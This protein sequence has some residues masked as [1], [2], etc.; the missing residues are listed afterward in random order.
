VDV[1][2]ALNFSGAPGVES[3][4]AGGY[5]GLDIA[6]VTNN[7][8]FT[9]ANLASLL[10]STF[11]GFPASGGIAP[12][13][14]NPA[15]PFIWY[16]NAGKFAATNIVGNSA[17]LKFGTPV[18]RPTSGTKTLFVSYLLSIAQQGQ[19]GAGNE[20]RYLAFVSSTN[21]V[22]GTNLGPTVVAFTNWAAMFN[23]F[24]T[25]SNHYACHGILQNVGNVSYYIG[26]CDSS[27]GK[28]WANSPLSVNF[29]APA[30]VVGAYVLNSGANQDTNIMW[31][32][33]STTTF[34]G[35]TPP[36]T[37]MQV[38][39]TNL[40]TMS[41]LGGLV[42]IDRVGNGASGGVGTNYIGSSEKC[43]PG[44]MKTKEPEN[45]V[46]LVT[47]TICLAKK[48]LD[49]IVDA[50]HAAVVDPVLPPGKNAALMAEESSGHLPHLADAR[51]VGPS[52]PLVEERLHLAIGGLLPKQAQGFLEQVASEQG[53]IVLERLIEARQFLLLHVLAAHQ[54]QIPDPLHGLLH[55]AA[56]FVDHLSAQTIQF[57]VHQLDDVE[58]VED[59]CRLGQV[60]HH[61]RPVTGTHVHG[62][63]LNLRRAQAQGPPERAQRLPAARPLATQMIWPVSRSMTKV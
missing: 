33:P 47:Q 55:R 42:L 17:V 43:L 37:P 3:G 10:P 12:I 34:G 54:Q 62:H 40:F 46:T 20:G 56:G 41:D 11:P 30:F 61:G 49:L 31:V 7:N 26:A 36:A 59:D 52:A 53:F 44:V 28:C 27:A 16:T 45:Q 32:N 35:L 39:T 14:E 4:P 24:G 21:L 8:I 2:G 60:L 63:S 51:F 50:F 15:Q 57:L 29:A 9:S 48:C 25:S 18:P 38:W 58:A 1:W 5:H 22:E 19:L 6:V 23:G 13:M